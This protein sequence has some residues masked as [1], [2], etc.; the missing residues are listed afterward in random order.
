MKV[1]KTTAEKSNLSTEI[2]LFTGLELPKSLKSRIVKEVGEYLIE[3]T[4]LALSQSKSP[5]SG[6]TFPRLS[7]DYREMKQ[8]EG[9]GGSPNLEF[10]GKLKDAISYRATDKGL[11]IGVFGKEAPKA[12]GH[13][14]FS[15]ESSLPQRRF[16]PKEGQNYRKAI[17]DIVDT[18][19]AENA[20]EVERLKASDFDGV[21]TKTAMWRTLEDIFPS[22]SRSKIRDAVLGTPQSYRLF[23]RLKFLSWLS[24]G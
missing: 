13:N 15:G 2:D 9:L 8:K 23:D 11:A 18:I 3:Q 19:V 21:E 16:L 1:I 20:V 6:E 4:N 24:D 14:N 10:T 17:K 5:V 12:D 22:L 7:H